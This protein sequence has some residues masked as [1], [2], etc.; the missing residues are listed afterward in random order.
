MQSPNKTTT[1]FLGSTLL[2]ASLLTIAIGLLWWFGRKDQREG[3]WDKSVAEPTV[4]ESEAPKPRIG[5]RKSS[6]AAESDKAPA[7][8]SAERRSQAQAHPNEEAP[9]AVQ[10]AMDLI[11]RGLWADAEAILRNYL[12]EHPKDEMALVEM[13]MIQLLDRKDSAAALPYLKEAILVNP[14]NDVVMEELLR[15]FEET[16]D[17]DKGLEFLSSLPSDP[18]SAAV[19]YGM[20]AALLELDRPQEALEILQR[21]VYDN[22][23]QSFDTRDTLA[24]AYMATGQTDAALREL[25][26]IAQGPYSSSQTHYT[27]LQMASIMIE[28]RQFADAQAILQSLQGSEDADGDTLA[29][30]MQQLDEQQQAQY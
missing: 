4:E 3:W 6:R 1:E 18:P 12:A 10:K 22:N 8:E 2:L 25:E 17:W 20:G 23:V 7:T 21:A 30:L 13:A 11:D 28:T 9:G 26:A 24:Q 27:K 19:S 5:Y 14:Q 16:Q 15:S 29:Y